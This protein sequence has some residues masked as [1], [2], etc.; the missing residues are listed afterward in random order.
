MTLRWGDYI[1]GQDGTSRS[2][3]ALWKAAAGDGH[4]TYVLGEGF[5]PRALV[6][7]RR[8]VASG[9]ATD[10]HLLSIMLTTRSGDELTERLA[11]ENRDGLEQIAKAPGVHRSRIEVPKVEEPSA[12]GLKLGRELF[13]AGYFEATSLI[14]VDVSAL[15]SSIHFPVIGAILKQADVGSL[16]AEFQVVACHNAELDE[17]IIESGLGPPSYVGGFGY[18]SVETTQASKVTRVWAPVVGKGQ[19]AA[20]QMLYDYL[21][22]DEVCPVLPFPA[23][24][25]RRSDDL[26]L[27]HR[28]LLMDRIEVEPRNLI[29]ADE[30]NSCDLYRTL[31]R[32]QR[33]YSEALKVLR[34]AT[35]IVSSHASKLLSLGV[36]LAAYEHSLPV[37]SAG[38]TGYSLA[39]GVNLQAI[40][41]N[42]RLA[43]L[44]LAGTPYV[45]APAQ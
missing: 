7:L 29:Y 27:E 13:S 26:I 39:D 15:P 8:L 45:S 23:R 10:L 31:S 36:L 32:L 1:S 28:Q 20:L 18:T 3:E 25:P 43:C 41:N 40:S 9:C 37:V 14:V 22:P 6:G 35:V 34:P 44:W 11:S 42:D 30:T 2:V 4:V 19:G 5:D 21:E 12:A 17:A 38:A 33:Q 16:R 24:W